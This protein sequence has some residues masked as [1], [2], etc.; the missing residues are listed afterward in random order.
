VAIKGGKAYIP[1]ATADYSAYPTISYSFSGIHVMDLTSETIVSTIDLTDDAN[2]H[3]IYLDPNGVLEVATA[4]GIQLIDA[5]TDTLIPGLTT[6]T[7]LH[8]IRFI[9]AHKAYAAIADGLVSF[10]PSTQTFIKDAGS[11]IPAGGDT[12]VGDFEINDGKAYVPNFANDTVTV[13]DLDT[14]TIVGTPFLVGD[15]PQAV[16]FQSP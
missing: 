13:L 10:D 8:S 4:T 9:S 14:E 1:A 6:P 7:T 12:S 11:K 16:V 5:G 2:P 3:G 15:G